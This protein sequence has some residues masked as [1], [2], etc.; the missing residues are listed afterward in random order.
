MRANASSLL[1]GLLSFFAGWF[2]T[3]V[4]GHPDAAWGN[5]KEDVRDICPDCHPD[6]D[7][8]GTC[9][10]PDNGA[11]ISCGFTTCACAFDWTCFPSSGYCSAKAG[12]IFLVPANAN[13]IRGNSG[14]KGLPPAGVNWEVILTLTP[15][16]FGCGATN[17]DPITICTGACNVACGQILCSST[18]TLTCTTCEIAR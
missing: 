13:S 15:V 4:S 10:M 18:V 6:Y 9:L 1:T 5:A 3:A 16:G 2:G 14:C 8:T 11:V 7:V 17:F 12:F